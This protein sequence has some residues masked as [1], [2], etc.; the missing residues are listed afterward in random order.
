MI[1]RTG[2]ALSPAPHQSAVFRRLLTLSGARRHIH[3][4]TAICEVQGHLGHPQCCEG[5]AN[6]SLGE[7]P[8]SFL[9]PQ[10]C[11]IVHT[12]DGAARPE[13]SWCIVGTEERRARGFEAE[14]LA[15]AGEAPPIVA[16]DDETSLALI[17]LPPTMTLQGSHLTTCKIRLLRWHLHAGRE[18][19]HR[20]LVLD[21][22]FALVLRCVL[23]VRAQAL[24]EQRRV[25]VICNNNIASKFPDLLRALRMPHGMHHAQAFAFQS[26]GLPAKKLQHRLPL[27]IILQQDLE[28]RRG[29][30]DDGVPRLRRAVA[31]LLRLAPEPM[32][33]VLALATQ[34]VELMISQYHLRATLLHKEAHR[35]H[36]SDGVRPPVHQ[37]SHEDQATA[38]GMHTVAV[39][40]EAEKQRLQLPALAVDVPDDVDRS[41]EE[42]SD[43]C[44]ARPSTPRRRQPRDRRLRAQQRA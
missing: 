25:V 14:I 5:G 8:A 15:A 19:R 18:H 40:A 36:H 39:V 29:R 42:L 26:Q 44:H 35:P 7:P 13:P 3:G 43:E 21:G 16:D 1:S 41:V 28:R 33:A 22:H 20:M 6:A 9:E 32:I 30:G 27:H 17:A 10:P 38:L 31:E 34:Q 24:I 37:I 23:Q 11:G 12:H 2:T 4:R